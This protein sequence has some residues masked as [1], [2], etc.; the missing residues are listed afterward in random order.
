MDYMKKKTDNQL[1]K[2]EKDIKRNFG[3]AYKKCAKDLQIIQSKLEVTED[4]VKRRNLLNSSK[5]IQGLM[6]NMV[7]D[8]HNASKIAIDS[9]N[10]ETR[11]MVRNNYLYT[12]F[13]LEQQ[14]GMSMNFS[15][16][17]TKTLANIIKQDSTVFKKLALNKVKDKDI[18]L[19]RL[20]GQ[21]MQGILTGEGI[22]KLA[23]RIEDVIQRSTS[24]C[25]RIARTETTRS[26]N[27]G[28]VIGI[29]EGI[30]AGLNVQKQWISA[31][32]SR[33]RHSHRSIN[34]Q[35]VDAKDTFGNGLEYPGDSNGGGNEVCNCRCSVV[36]V[37]GEREANEI[38][39]DNDIMNMSFEEWG[40]LNG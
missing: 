30:K 36:G 38:N 15:V 21:L 28:R 19:R 35:I 20:Q 33:T 34:M 26:E 4:L 6:D 18:I 14:V 25:I 1:K 13:D 16:Y 23:K 3:E 7:I 9:I 12:L 29:E 32:D 27:Q 22:P 5:R 11:E 24:D 10:G 39:L 37:L 2:L 31:V 17:N 40:E 8:I